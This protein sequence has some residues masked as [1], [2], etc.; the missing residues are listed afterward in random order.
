M[1][2]EGNHGQIRERRFNIWFSPPPPKKKNWM[3]PYMADDAPP[4]SH[5]SLDREDQGRDKRVCG[6]GMVS[7]DGG[8][9]KRRVC[10][11]W[12]ITEIQEAKDPTKTQEAKVLIEDSE[13]AESRKCSK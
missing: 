2:P 1:I 12:E 9:L 7:L 11:L 6:D 3:K 8:M 5:Y 10:G 13:K 4:L